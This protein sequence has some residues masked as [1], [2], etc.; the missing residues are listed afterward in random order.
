[1]GFFYLLGQFVV[2]V[3]VVAG[4]PGDASLVLLLQFVLQCEEGWVEIQCCGWASLAGNKLYQWGKILDLK[5]EKMKRY[6]TASAI[7]YCE[8]KIFLQ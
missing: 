1:M 8:K 5:I 7:E 2:L 3:V 6:S 4:F